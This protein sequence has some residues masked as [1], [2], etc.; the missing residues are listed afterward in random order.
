MSNPTPTA[1]TTLCGVMLCWVVFA[2]VFVFRK[3]L[4]Q[5]PEAKRDNVAFFG[6]AL[7]GCAYGLV[8]FQRPRSAFLPPVEALSGAAGIAFGVFTVG[9]AAASVWLVSSAVR[10]LGKQWA[11][12]ARLVEDHKLITT[13]PYRYVRNPIYTGMYGMLIA[14][15]LATEHWIALI[16]G[17]VIFAIGLVIRVRSEEKLLRSAFGEEFEEYARRVPAVVPGIY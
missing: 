15:G 2:A 4:P 5:E 1:L 13:G 6:I 9:I 8:W 3:R 14:T 12:A 7:Q 16:I 11:V 10:H 17:V